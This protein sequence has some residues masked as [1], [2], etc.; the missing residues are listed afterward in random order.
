MT[1]FVTDIV[2]YAL[3]RA[4]VEAT[5]DTAGALINSALNNF[6]NDQ[7]NSAIRRVNN[8]ETVDRVTQSTQEKL[9]AATREVKVEFKANPEAAIPVVYGEAF[10]N[11]QV[12]DAR[13]TNNNCTM[14]Y[15]ITVSE[16]TGDILSTAED[17]GEGGTTYTASEIEFLEIYIDEKRIIFEAD[18]VTAQGWDNN[19]EIEREVA[20]LI[21]CYPYKRGSEAP[22]TWKYAGRTLQHGNAYDLM[23]GWDS[24]W[25]MS[26]LAFVL[27]RIDYD[28]ETEVTGI[29]NLKIRVNN[30]MYLPGDCIYDYMTNTRYGAGIDQAEIDI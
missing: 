12:T 24:D 2:K 18:G 5:G 8:N 1:T 29:N 19:G 14:W 30:T 15:C 3:G 23:P 6:L 25:Q 27:I 13:L 7:L 26:D 20:G 22:T 9:E 28:K 17:D 11:G 16:A 10:V 21:R 4:G